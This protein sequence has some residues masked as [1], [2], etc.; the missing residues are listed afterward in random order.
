MLDDVQAIH[1]YLRLLGHVHFLLHQ[2]RCVAPSRMLEGS[3]PAAIHRVIVR[4]QHSTG[5]IVGVGW[6]LY[7]V[8]NLGYR[9]VGVPYERLVGEVGVGEDW[10]D[11]HNR[12]VQVVLDL[13]S[14]GLAV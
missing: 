14:V 10:V 2:K 7:L 1:R 3:R 13:I 9:L 11:N 5:G 6:A 8:K 4:F 12:I